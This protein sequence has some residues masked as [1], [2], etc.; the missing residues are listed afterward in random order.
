[1]THDGGETWTSAILPSVTEV[2][3]GAGYVYALAGSVGP[4]SASLWRSAVDSNVW[5][6]ISL[7][8]RNVPLADVQLSAEGDTLLLLQQGQF[9]PV[10]TGFQ[11]GVLWSSTDAGTQWIQRPVPCTP[12]DGG[13]AVASIASLHPDAWLI[14]CFDNEQSMQEQE[15]QHHLYGSADAGAHWVRLADPSKTGYPTLMAEQRL[16]PCVPRDGSRWFRLAHGHVRRSQFLDDAVLDARL[17][18]LGRPGVR[19]RF[20]RI[21]CR[22]EQ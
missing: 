10:G 21:R 8:S 11:V 5:A 7:P 6:P 15:T 1:M 4:D 16:W 13:A 19:R 12:D 9:G 22:S 20:H 17:L 18:R 14:D 3:S 2:T